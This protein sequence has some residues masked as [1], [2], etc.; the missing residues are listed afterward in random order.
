MFKEELINFSQA[1]RQSTL[2]RLNQ[3]P[4]NY[5]NW[6]PASS[7]LSVAEIAQ[8]IIDCDYWL[9][10]KMK[11]ESLKSILAKANSLII[12]KR[13]EFENLLT[14]LRDT[15][16]K[17]EKLIINLSPD[18]LFTKLYDDRFKNDVTIWW[19]I[20]RGN[21]DHEIHHRGQLALYLKMIQQDQ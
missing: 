9:F 7:L 21:L 18:M 6:K 11:N 12:H 13:V 19:I 2:E 3:V 8:H 15:Q 1:V 4:V 14:E 16:K 17:R 20:I 10:E 5:E